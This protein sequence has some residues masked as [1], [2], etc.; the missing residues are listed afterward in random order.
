MPAVILT[1][2]RQAGKSTLVRHGETA[3]SRD[4]YDVDDIATRAALVA[5][6]DLFKRTTADV[7]LDEVQREPEL[8]LAVKRAVDAMGRKRRPGQFLL[9]GSAN[10]LT[11]R[12]V[13]DALTGRAAYVTLWPL[14]RREQLGLG[15]TGDWNACFDLP[16]A[17]WGRHFE[18]TSAPRADWRAIVSR[19]CYPTP[20]LEIDD[21][22]HRRHW[23]TGY[24]NGF[25][26]HDLR[27][28]AD[29]QDLPK[30]RDLLTA[31]A[32][33]VGQ[34]VNQTE[35]G[36]DVQLSQQRVRGYLH[37]LETVYQV[38]RLPAY[39]VSRTTRLIKSPK[40][41]YSDPGVA[42]FLAGGDTPSGGLFENLVL[43][44]LLAW[45]ASASRPAELHYW[46]TSA[47]AEVD[48]VVERDGR[49]LAIEVKSA[50][51]VRRGD[52]DGLQAFRDEY[53]KRV[54][55]GLLLYDGDDVKP[56]GGDA[57]AVP[58]WQML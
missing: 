39:T 19:G 16:P 30:F 40:L 21:D 58:W 3:R 50:R 46:R 56:L 51:S 22:A 57:Y 11:M 42:C 55:G 47:G 54:I 4:F 20:A 37:L 10:L 29:V 35:L 38:V 23:F 12:R 6:P 31:I 49:L 1:G 26:H 45:S 18:R 53:G 25:M 44:D 5:D 9:T 36:R 48:F 52:A 28:L 24:V 2:P 34:L 7:T 43:L 17:E 27:D 14:T 32:L 8:L 15:T 41:Y 13:P 33:R